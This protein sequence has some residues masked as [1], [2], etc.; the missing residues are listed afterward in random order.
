M[1]LAVQ[2][3]CSL[4][5]HAILLG[6]TSGITVSKQAVHKR[7]AAHLPE[8]LQACLGAA[9]RFR[10]AADRSLGAGGFGRILVQ[11]STC[12]S[13][14]PRLAA[15]FPGPANHTGK[16]QASVRIQC[17]YDLLSESFAWFSLSA[18]TRNDQSAATDVLGLLKPNDLL[19]RDLGYFTLASLKGI[20][21]A[22]A[23]FLTRWRYKVALLDCDT[24][25]P[26]NLRRLLRP[27]T[28]LERSVLLGENKKLPV[29]LVAIALPEPVA[30]ERRRKARANRDRRLNHSADYMYLLG[31]NL[32]LT[33][34]DAL[35]L[36]IQQVSKLYR[37]RWRIEIIFK[38]WKSHL[39]LTRI[40]KLGSRQIEALLYG[41]LLL[42][43]LT[44]RQPL[45]PNHCP[46]PT[47]SVSRPQ[48]PALSLL[49]LSDF[50]GNYLLVLLLG[51]LPPDQ[52]LERLLDQINAHARYDRRKRKN[53]VQSRQ[54]S[55]G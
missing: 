41:L 53:Y 40:D 31:W 33:N 13:L 34:A 4:R 44:H 55:L 49:R 37:L 11:D 46:P 29:R 22:K 42:V 32:F 26:L 6:I 14:S 25:E 45:A 1:V 47:G 23:F 15:R 24:G 16:S 48:P 20:A 19:I 2:N 10:L 5:Q 35:R 17:L 54:D 52:L 30:N 9:I 51:P 50:I 3:S 39:G 7:L 43:V 21:A 38:A 28:T 18:F 12:V 36:P 27:G 8:F